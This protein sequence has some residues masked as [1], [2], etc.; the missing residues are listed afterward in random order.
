MI[1]RRRQSSL[2]IALYINAALLA[3]VIVI[4]LSR[5]GGPTLIAPAMGQTAEQPAIA[6]GAGLFVVPAQFADH[7][8]GC[9]LMDVD[10]QTLCAYEYY[11]GD[12]KLRLTAARSLRYDRK[13]EQ[14]NTGDPS[15]TEVKDLIEKEK[16]GLRGQPAPKPA[17]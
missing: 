6:G 1:R 13:L 15:P 5:S 16:A 14:F 11:A 17:P 3:C 2:V 10:S 8:W 9:Y 12:K 4:L 7:V